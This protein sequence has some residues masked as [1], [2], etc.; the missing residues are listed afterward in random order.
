M[1]E[2]FRFD[3]SLLNRNWFDKPEMLPL[4]MHLLN[5]ANEE[6]KQGD[7]LVRRGQ[8][9]T[10]LNQLSDTTGIS[11]QT[12]RTCLGKLKEFGLIEIEAN[13]HYSVIAVC[14][15]DRYLG[16]A[17]VAQRSEKKEVKTPK[18]KAE[19][20]KK[21][22]DELSADTEKRKKIFYQELVPYVETY[23][24][25]MVREFFD[26]WSEPNKSRSKMRYEQ[27]KTWDLSRRLARWANHNKD[28]KSNGNKEME[29][30]IGEAASLVDSLLSTEQTN[31]G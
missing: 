2:W 20:P 3:R 4:F 25:A 11:K 5:C 17:V 22:K 16:E 1:Q 6:D 21:S 18:A 9:K 8:V 30:R 12:L 24:R 31:Q 26:Y 23:G 28:Y 19:K 29:Q 15:F 7:V 27:E 13:N 10:S 14:N